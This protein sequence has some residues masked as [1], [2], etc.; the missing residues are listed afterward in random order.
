[1]YIYVWVDMCAYLKT[2][3]PVMTSRIKRK[4]KTYQDGEESLSIGK[5]FV[6]ENR[7]KMNVAEF[8]YRYFSS[9]YFAYFVCCNYI[10]VKMI[11]QVLIVC[12]K[13]Q[14]NVK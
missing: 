7:L 11:R 5:I 3:P 10:D 4:L 14:M 9:L 8:C 1:M 13:C 12:D 2:C 6:E